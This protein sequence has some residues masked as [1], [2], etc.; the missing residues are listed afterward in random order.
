MGH[1][2]SVLTVATCLAALA[3]HAGAVH[4]ATVIMNVT[5]VDGTGAAAR[6]G[7]VRIVADRIVAVGNVVRE[8]GDASLDGAGLVLAPGFIDTHS[9][10]DRGLFERREALAPIGQG[11]TTIVVGQD[12]FSPQ[13]LT[14]FFSRFEAAPAA[15]NVASYS[16]HNTLRAAVLRSDSRRVATTTEI[17]AMA[18]L[19]EQDLAAG[20]L[21]LSTGLAYEPGIFSNRAEV[22]QLARVAAHRAAR[23]VSHIR[24]E[25]VSLLDALDEAIAVAEQARLPVQ[26][27]HL[28]IGLKEQWGTADRVLALLDR[29]RA[30]GAQ[31]TADVYP[32]TYW[33]TTMRLLLE[34]KP[35]NRERVAWHFAHTTPPET[36]F[37]QRYLPDPSLVNRNLA[38]LARERGQDAVTLYLE[39]AKRAAEYERAHP[40]AE[41]PVE[42][43]I[44]TS[45]A[46]EDVD[47]FARWEHSNVCSDGADGGHPRGYGAFTRIL[48][49]QVREQRALTLETAVRKMTGL[50]ARNLGLRGRGTI[51]PGAHADLVLFDPRTVADRATVQQPTALSS[52]IAKVWVAGELVYADARPTHRYPGRI[53]RREANV[54]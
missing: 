39:L 23:Y 46:Q 16:G 47:R 12:G 35:D 3:M 1:L 4:S 52:G 15:V 27:S 44:G 36:I 19:L 48:A 43:I 21:G 51:E 54:Q 30:R 24:N 53:I 11:V 22:V 20:A 5:I 38:Q 13:P 14:D 18:A 40:A 25:N 10:H 50:A 32:Y 29:A 37:L 33:Q 17:E 6:P 42:S 9:H 28:K 7:A 26:I 41:R 8:A 49:Q 34:G 31:I 45:M 2:R